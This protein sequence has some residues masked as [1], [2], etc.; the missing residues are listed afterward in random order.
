[1]KPHA[2]SAMVTDPC[3]EALLAKNQCV[4][5]LVS[6]YCQN[7][8][9]AVA[10]CEETVIVIRRAHRQEWYEFPWCELH[11]TYL[12]YKALHNRLDCCECLR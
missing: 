10:S 12:R 2:V 8:S 3:A 4:Y 5:L 6:F 11:N 9:A 1:M 7:L